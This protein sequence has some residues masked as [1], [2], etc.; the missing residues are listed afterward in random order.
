MLGLVMMLVTAT[1][2]PPTCLAMLPQ[3]FSAATTEILPPGPDLAPA[4]PVAQLLT[5]PP[6]RR[7][8]T[9]NP[10]RTDLRTMAS[11]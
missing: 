6:T 9:T 8:P 3:K 2:S 11:G 4:L 7:A 1:R 5:A 10:T